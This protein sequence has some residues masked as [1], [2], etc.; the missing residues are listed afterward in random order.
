MLYF[1][2]FFIPVDSI[3]FP[4]FLALIRPRKFIFNQFFE[5]S[6]NLLMVFALSCL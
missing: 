6:L 2:N 5:P 3:M 4:E 1:E